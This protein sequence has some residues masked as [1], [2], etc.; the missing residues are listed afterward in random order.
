MEIAWH[1]QGQQVTCQGLGHVTR[2]G[3]PE[4][5]PVVALTMPVLVGDP[6]LKRVVGVDGMLDVFLLL[7]PHERFPCHH[8]V[9]LSRTTTRIQKILPQT[10]LLKSCADHCCY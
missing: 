4:K 2:N 1:W 8:P 5:C 9:G 10:L 3:I 7:S 6:S